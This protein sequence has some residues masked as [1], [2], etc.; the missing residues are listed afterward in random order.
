MKLCGLVKTTLLDFPGHLAATL[1]IGGCNFSCPY[2]HNKTLV[3]MPSNS[4]TLSYN[5]LIEF[6]SKRKEILEGICITGGEPTLHKDI[7]PLIK[8]IK[9]LGYKVKLDTNGSNPEILSTLYNK[10]YLDYIAMDIKNSPQKYNNTINLKHF[11]LS[12][13]NKSID[14]IMSS[15]VHY[16]FRT[17]IVKELHSEQDIIDIGKWIKGAKFYFLQNF[18][19]SKEQLVPGFSSHSKETLNHYI[20]ILKPYILNVSLRGID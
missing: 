3:Q 14:L 13:I 9:N 19:P 6:L 17:T 15:T 11:D 8:D 5:S 7:V 2:C 16:E 20:D 18:Q 1:F 4:S 10:K 12:S